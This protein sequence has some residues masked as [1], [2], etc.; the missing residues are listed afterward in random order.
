MSKN[1]LLTF[2]RALKWGL[3]GLKGVHGLRVRGGEVEE[4]NESFSLGHMVQYSFF[5]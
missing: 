4:I 3:V 5:F 2:L 1:H